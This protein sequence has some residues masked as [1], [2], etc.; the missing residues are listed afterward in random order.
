MKVM[1]VGFWKEVVLSYFRVVLCQVRFRKEV[2][3]SYF[4]IMLG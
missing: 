3:V 2:V 4:K 1:L